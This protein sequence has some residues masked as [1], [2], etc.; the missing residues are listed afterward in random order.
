M[1]KGVMAMESYALSCSLFFKIQSY[2]CKNYKVV[3]PSLYV[4]LAPGKGIFCSPTR[5][6]NQP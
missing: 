2:T 3:K 4:S 6:G 5:C 1:F